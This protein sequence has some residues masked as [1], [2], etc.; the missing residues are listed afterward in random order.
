MLSAKRLRKELNL[1]SADPVPDCVALPLESN[2]LEW[3]FIIRGSKDSD[4]E[5]GFYHGKLRW[6]SGC[7][8]RCSAIPH[9]FPLR[10]PIEYPY[11]PPSILFVTP[12]GRFAINQRICMS[13][14]DFHPETWSPLW[15]VG[16]LLT[17]TKKRSQV[18]FLI[19]LYSKESYHSWILKNLR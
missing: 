14:S 10:F 7:T 8:L 4:Y 3:R 5:G 1:L 2:I 19:N 15:S 18:P 17:G 9:D 16:S 6:V 11:K 13:M 12:S